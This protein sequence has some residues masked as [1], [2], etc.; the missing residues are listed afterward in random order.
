[1]GKLLSFNSDAKTKKGN[2]KVLTGILFLAPHDISGYQVCPKATKGCIKACLYSAGMGVYKNV[3]AG[4]IR[5]TKLFFEDRETFMNQLVADIQA[6]IRKGKRENKP[7][8]I[9]LNGTSDIAWEKIKVT[10]DGTNYRNLMAAFPD[11]QF[12]DY[13]KI[14]GRKAAVNIPNYHLTF[15]LAEDNDHDAYKALKQGYSVAVVLDVRRSESKPTEW[16]GVKMIDG[17]TDDIRF[18]DQ[19]G[20]FVGLTAKGKARYDEIGFVRKP[21]DSLQVSSR[22]IAKG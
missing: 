14:P 19:K 2:D 11:I 5:K 10:V 12:Y 8:A 6:L 7:V 13:T 17:D 16:S 9:R 20:V 4:R 22:L 3:Q 1:M 15:S 21:T 18:H